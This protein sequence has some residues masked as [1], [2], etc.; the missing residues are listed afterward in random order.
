MVGKPEVVV[1]YLNPQLL[2][3]RQAAD[4]R[5]PV[6]LQLQLWWNDPFWD[7]LFSNLATLVREMRSIFASSPRLS[8]RSRSR[9]IA[10]RST[11]RGLRPMR[12]PSSWARRIP[13]RTRSTISERSNSAIAPMIVMTARPN[14]PAV[15]IFSRRLTNSI[16]R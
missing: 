16:P 8:P 1:R 10:W 9:R 13:A 11:S 6:L 15:S 2:R 12:R 14:G 5:R 3:Q 4:F 7:T